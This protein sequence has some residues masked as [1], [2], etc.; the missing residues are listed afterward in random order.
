MTWRAVATLLLAMGILAGCAY[1]GV[2][3]D[4]GSGA[5][6]PAGPSASALPAQ[7]GC[8]DANNPA[9]LCIVVLGDSIAAGAPLN[10]DRRWWVRL[11]KQLA[12]AMPDRDVVVDNW[13]V[14]GS[15]IDVLEAASRLQPGLRSYHLAIVIEGVN[16]EG[17][18]PV[19]EW[20]PRYESAIAAMESQG[21]TVIV[22][23]PP[24]SLEGGTFRTRYDS[25]ADLIRGVASRGRPLLD[26][27]AR[28]HQDGPAIASSYY[29]DLIHQADA[30]QQQMADLAEQV[31]LGVVRN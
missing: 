12:N 10:D 28:W 7:A 3:R 19:T 4:P 14:S 8:R 13:A 17:L 20:Q 16:D 27:A 6:V 29:F 22:T 24:P 11:R 9:A 25:A 15:R 21:L 1:S 2:G 18:L 30:G 23:T 5:N 31:V 26:V